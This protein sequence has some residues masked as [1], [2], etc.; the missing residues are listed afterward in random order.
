MQNPG[1]IQPIDN[2]LT[3][4]SA[5]NVYLGSGIKTYQVNPDPVAEIHTQYGNTNTVTG[6]KYIGNTTGTQITLGALCVIT[7]AKAYEVF[8]D[9]AGLI[10]TVQITGVNQNDEEISENINTSGTSVVVTLNNYKCV[11]DMVLIAGGTLTTQVITCRP[12]GATPQDQRVTLS[13]TYKI[14]PFFMCS[15]KNGLQRK[16]RLR[17]INSLL[18]V[19]ANSSVSLH[20]CKAGISTGANLAVYNPQLRLFDLG[21]VQGIT[22]SDDGIVELSA[23]EMAVWYRE[24]TTTTESAIS[25][26]WSYFYL[27]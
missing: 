13:G 9:T 25:A 6:A 3:L 17:S 27:S 23:G 22:Y 2:K 7:T 16:A 10:R 12:N 26:S 19:T 20:V 11:N 21:T 5:A 15:N 14:N 1:V 4:S 8:T 24:S 18:A